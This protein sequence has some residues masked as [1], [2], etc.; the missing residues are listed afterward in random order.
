MIKTRCKQSFLAPKN[1]AKQGIY[2]GIHLSQGDLHHVGPILG[3]PIRD[4]FNPKGEIYGTCVANYFEEFNDAKIVS[5][6][7]VKPWE[8][9]R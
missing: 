6:E 5:Q 4:W 7:L 9:W 8:T 1:F 3:T 2:G